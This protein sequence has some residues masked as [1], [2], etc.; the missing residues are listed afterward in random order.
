MAKSSSFGGARGRGGHRGQQE[1]ERQHRRRRAPPQQRGQAGAEHGDDDR[2]DQEQRER[3]RQ[4][5]AAEIARFGVGVARV[6]CAQARGVE[7]R[8][9]VGGCQ[10]VDGDR[11]FRRA[12]EAGRVIQ[13]RAVAIVGRHRLGGR[14]R[15]TERAEAVERAQ[16]RHCFHFRL[17]RDARAGCRGVA[18]HVDQPP[19][20][21][22]EAAG[23]RQVRP[24]RV[25]ADMEQ[26]DHALAAMLA[27]DER[28]AVFQRCP[29]LG[30]EHGIR[31]GRAPAGSP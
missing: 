17:A 25:G 21:L 16:R 30:G 22:D 14:G 23:H 24:A 7:R 27:G 1:R 29:A 28:R 6:P 13:R 5:D 9:A 2:V 19:Q 4:Q 8:D 15:R 20:H 18:G 3:G 12:V 31:L 26:A 10:R 11:A